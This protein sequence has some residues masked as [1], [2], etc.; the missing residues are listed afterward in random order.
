ML[1]NGIPEI[2]LLK[3]NFELAIVSSCSRKVILHSSCRFYVI[4]RCT[5][6]NIKIFIKRDQLH[7]FR[8]PYLHMVYPFYNCG[9]LIPHQTIGG[10]VSEFFSF[11]KFQS[12]KMVQIADISKPNLKAR[13]F[14]SKSC[15]AFILINY[16]WL[17]GN[18]H[19][20]TPQIV[21]L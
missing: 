17:Y 7:V 1:I 2:W 21:W 9:G 18:E 16:I 8:K 15:T 20:C 14:L 6:P 4:V 10:E 13:H 5:T 3:S 19:L 12:Y 11:E